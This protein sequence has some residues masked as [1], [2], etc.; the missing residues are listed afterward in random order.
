MAMRTACDKCGKRREWGGFFPLY[1]CFVSSHSIVPPFSIPIPIPR[2][3][4]SPRLVFVC[5][6]KMLP[7]PRA[8]EVR[9]ARSMCGG[10]RA[11]YLLAFSFPGRSL[12]TARSLSLPCPF[13]PSTAHMAVP[14]LGRFRLSPAG[15]AGLLLMRVVCDEQIE[16]ALLSDVAPHAFSPCLA[17]FP[18]AIWQFGL[19]VPA[20]SFR[21][22]CR[23]R[24][25]ACV[26]VSRVV[27]V[28][29]R[30]VPGS[31][32]GCYRSFS[33]SGVF[34]PSSRIA[35]RGGRAGRLCLLVAV[36]SFVPAS[37]MLSACS[38]LARR[39]LLG[40]RRFPVVSS[41][42]F[43]L[44]RSVYRSACG[45]CR[46]RSR[47]S[48]I[49]CGVCCVGGAFHRYRRLSSSGACSCLRYG[50]D[51]LSRCLLGLSCRLRVWSVFRPSC[52]GM[53]DA[54][55]CFVAAV[56]LIALVPFLMPFCCPVCFSPPFAPSCDTGGGAM[57]CGVRRHLIDSLSVPLLAVLGAGRRVRMACYNPAP[58]S[59]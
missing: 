11:D 1:S 16:T 47:L 20:R 5:L 52:V 8:W 10:W 54:S 55:F 56:A 48:F 9:A 38:F 25:L 49:S 19:S 14:F 28:P 33:S 4:P 39:C 40:R 58:C 46:P 29:S 24:L 31:V 3:T 21:L 45:R 34:A 13:F 44:V 30:S 26:I 2:P 22:P 59:S 17:S 12:A 27:S 15:G 42:L 50:V 57:L 36:G 37:S 43:C 7:R 35:G 18:G 23:L 41:C 6:L 32:G 53:W 51:A